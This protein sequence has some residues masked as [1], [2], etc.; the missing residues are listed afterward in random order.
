MQ[1]ASRLYVVALTGAAAVALATTA[2][3]E[4]GKGHA[5]SHGNKVECVLTAQ[6]RGTTLGAKGHVQFKA[7]AAA[8]NN[9]TIRL[10]VNNKGRTAFGQAHLHGPRPATGV[11][12]SLFAGE[13]LSAKKIRRTQMVTI[14]AAQRQDLCDKSKKFYVDVHLAADAATVIAGDLR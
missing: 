14:T 7:L 9:L 6:L 4:H 8:A 12:V 2:G 1:I 11:V 13:A 3:A 10:F 5:K